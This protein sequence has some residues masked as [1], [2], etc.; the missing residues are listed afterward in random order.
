[1]GGGYAMLPL[2]ETEFVHKKK[3]FTDEDYMNMIT[4]ITSAPGPLAV[5]S[6]VYTGYHVAGLLGSIFSVLGVII[7]PIVI[8][9]CIIPFYTQFRDLEIIDKV[10]QGIRPAVVGLI[11]GAVYNMVK[12]S[13]IKGYWLIVPIISFCIIVVFNIGPVFVIIA[14]GILGF[15]KSIIDKEKL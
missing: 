14:L 12:K 5:N 1:M 6:A 9:L 13:K 10:F 15:F 2:F 3:W 8:I 7:P 11:I 4:I